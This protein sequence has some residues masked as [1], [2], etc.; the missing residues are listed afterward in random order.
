MSLKYVWLLPTN[1]T[2]SGGSFDTG[3]AARGAVCETFSADAAIASAGGSPSI[4][5]TKKPSPM[6]ITNDATPS[7]R[8]IA[9]DYMRIG[10]RTLG[11][12][13]E[14]AGVAIACSRL[15]Y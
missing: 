5:Q 8:C 1:S 4:F 15:G 14:S 3:S 9:R 10:R 2:R 11:F 7:A 13:T 12:L 6:A